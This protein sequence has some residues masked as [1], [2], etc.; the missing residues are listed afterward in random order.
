[1]GCSKSSSKREVY[2][3]VILPQETRIKHWI[4]NLALYLKQ[5]EKEEEKKNTRG[6]KSIKI[7]GEINENEMKETIVK[8]NKL[9]A[10]S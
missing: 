2:S 8:I 10:G 3:D 9:K 6:K 7:Q 5:L 4:D 1:M